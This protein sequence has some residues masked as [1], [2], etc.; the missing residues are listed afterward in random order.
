MKAFNLLTKWIILLL[1]I[2]SVISISSAQPL[3]L[4][5]GAHPKFQHQLPIPAV[6]QPITTGGNYYE[7]SMSQ[8]QQFLGLYDSY[9]N[10]LMTTVWGYN[11]Y[12][13]GPTIEATVNQPITVKWMNNLT[14]GAGNPLP[15]LLP[16]DTTL[17]WAHPHSW[18]YGGVPTVT[19][20]HGGHT[21]S[22][23]DG[24]PEAWFTPGFA[25]TGP[26]FVK[27]D[28]YYANDQ[29]A[30]TLWYHDHALGITRLNV[31]A[32]LAGFYLLR[33]QLENNLNLPSG[34]YEILLVI[35]DRMFYADGSLYYPHELEYL[36]EEGIE[37][38]DLDFEITALPEMFGDFILVNGMAWPYLEVEPRKYR[39]RFLNGSDS[40]FYNMSMQ[41]VTFFVIGTDGGLLNAPV[42]LNKLLIA[43]GERMDVII[44]FSATNLL[45][46]TL[47]LKNDARSPY[48]FGT[49]VDPK[50]SGQIMAFKVTKPLT[51]P[52]LSQLP[53]LLRNT[54]IMPLGTTDKVR[55]LVLFEGTDEYGRLKPLLGTAEQGPLEFFAPLTENP[56]IGEV[57]LWEIINTT[58]DAHPIHLH[59]VFFQVQNTQKFNRSKFIAGDPA[60][61]QPIGQPKAPAAEHSGWKDTYV[62]PPG[63]IARV[64]AMFDKEGLY[65]WHCHILSHEDHEMMRPFYV[66]NMMAKN[67]EETTEKLQ[68]I[69]KEGVTIYPNPARDKA[70]I[71]IVAASDKIH[72]T[73]HDLN[74]KIVADLTTTT[75]TSGNEY[76]F[77]FDGSKLP[78]G[79]YIYSLMNG[80]HIKK[81]KIILIK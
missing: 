46:K 23:S 38:D 9:G 17:H 22:A 67:M 68:P 47:I 15:H 33:S 28:Y 16:V 76:L 60:S 78:G 30:A 64:K 7:A 36:E 45:G 41:G 54:P 25:E 3:L 52:D 5:A 44:D 2:L 27:E 29:E 57:E 61:I 31:Y 80:D 56:Q 35:Q 70:I 75:I 4:D 50:T 20:L 63:E 79:T 62:V 59:L 58:P 14:D 37:P 19:H 40:R 77:E 49:T 43:P 21:E 69:E 6:M 48:P 73:I 10:Q 18:P 66:G 11:G 71:S 53:Q 32:G 34:A 12:Y 81:G 74:G 1:L 65:V 8:F 26:F 24:Y 55:Q 13:P 39:L 42:E 51:A 72:L